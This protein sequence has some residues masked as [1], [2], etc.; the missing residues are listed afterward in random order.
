MLFYEPIGLHLRSS[1]SSKKNI[2]HLFVDLRNATFDVRRRQV[3]VGRPRQQLRQLSAVGLELRGF[4]GRLE[5]D[6]TREKGELEVVEVQISDARLDLLERHQQVDL[7]DHALNLLLREQEVVRVF[8]FRQSK[9][10]LKEPDI[11]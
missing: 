3:G 4:D 9:N 7:R 5:A 6:V 1:R 2:Y 11:R 8:T 10:C